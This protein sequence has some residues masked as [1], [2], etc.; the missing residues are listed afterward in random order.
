MSDMDNDAL[1]GADDATL[2]ND[3]VSG[4]AVV[5]EPE[6]IAPVAPVE[7][8]TPPTQQTEPAIP[9]GVLREEKEARRAAE[10]RAQEL[11]ARLDAFMRQQ[12]P[13]Q[14]PRQKPDMFEN[15]SA[16]VQEEV[17]PHLSQLQAELVRTRETY[18]QL[19][20]EQKHGAEKV[21]AAFNWIKDG[22]AQRDP[23]IIQTYQRAMQTANPY[24]VITRAH[25]QRQTISEIG[26]DLPGYRNRVLEEAMKDPA[27]QAKVIEATRQQ[28][29]QSGQTIAR[30]VSSLPSI[31]KVGA[32]ALPSGQ[33][34]EMSDAEL[35]AAATRRKRG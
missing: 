30:P 20:A 25:L 34:A 8:Q 27:F 1:A 23:E 24:D 18:S 35:F 7:P 5:P 2:F 32:A 33:E 14:E 26:D 22:L 9:P 6:V 15:P 17:S 16:F 21:Q 3:A 12:Q 28:A 10:R 19:F 31:T 4:P 29:Q 13:K 11:E